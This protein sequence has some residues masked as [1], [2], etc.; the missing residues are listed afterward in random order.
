MG[1][2]EQEYSK[3]FSLKIWKNVLPFLKPF[4]RILVMVF[5]LNL[6]CAGMDILLPLFQRYA[7]NHFIEAG[8]TGGLVPFAALYA[9]VIVLQMAATFAFTRGC[10]KVEMNLGRDLKR[11]CFV[12]LQTLSFSYYNTTPVGYILSRV[13]SDTD[14]I[15][16]LVAWNLSDM[17]WA[18]SYV[19]GVFIAMMALDPRLA[20]TVILVVPAIA[21]VTF[22]FQNRILY[23][24]RK[25]RKENSWIT[26]SFN[27][28]IMGAKTSKTLVI[29]EKNF[30]DF[31][32]IS[33]GMCVASIRSARLSAVYI[34]LVLLLSSIATAV[35]LASGGGMVRRQAL[36][37]GTLSAFLSYAVGIF[38]PIQQLARNFSEVI[39][40][41]ANIERVGGLLNKQP[42]IVDSAEVVEK[43]GDSFH[44]KKENWEPIRGDIEFDDVSFRYSDGKE[45]VL[46][47]FSLKIPAR[48]KMRGS[49]STARANEISC[50]SPV[51]R[52]SPPSPT[53]LA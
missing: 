23:W 7:I 43:Y 52:R 46:T 49:A 13:M 36:L 35:V 12:H 19:F 29:E 18:A 39:S 45:D 11:A 51:E 1:Y 41:Q 24:N 34:S 17:L 27:E 16:G 4:R 48:T 32:G 33:R 26:G 25:V 14:R 28:G 5:V 3:S 6:F 53:S 15:A 8:T 31:K 37:F 30:Q 42:E 21:L 40:V 47:H 50:F 20:L 10:M 2:D 38:E 9:A 44:P 22:Y